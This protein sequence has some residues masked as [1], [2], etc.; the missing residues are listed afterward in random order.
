MRVKIAVWGNS[1]GL[2]VPKAVA[3]QLGLKSGS[4]V[5]MTLDGAVATFAAAPAAAG[6]P[7]LEEMVAEMKRL[8]AEGI[9]PP[10]LIDWGPDVGAEIID[11]GGYPDPAPAP[12]SAR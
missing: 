1:L 5:E 12:G 4:E 9:E 3:D 2:R 6:R 11:D 7:K 10:E 8:M